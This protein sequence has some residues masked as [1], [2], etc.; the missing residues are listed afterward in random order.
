MLTALGCHEVNDAKIITVEGEPRSKARPRFGWKKVYVDKNQKSEQEALTFFLRAHFSA[1]L[2][3]NVAVACLFFRS[4]RHSVDTDNMLK[5]VL[6]AGT[7]WCWKDDR[8]VTAVAGVAFLDRV[9][10]RLCVGI[11]RHVSTLDR[12]APVPG[13]CR[14]CG[15]AFPGKHLAPCQVAGRNGAFCSTA[16]AARWRGTDRTAEANCR[17]CSKLFR[18]L[19]AGHYYCS[20]DCRLKAMVQ[21]NYLARIRPPSFCQVCKGPV[22]RPEYRR[23]RK[24]WTL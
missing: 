20:Q 12:S 17:G 9:S 10:P 4:S 3:G 24:C 21:R 11:A 2:E 18:R 14:Q 7:G 15:K 19:R 1:P 13:S 22:S 6:D 8:Q 5:Q 23:C 16:C